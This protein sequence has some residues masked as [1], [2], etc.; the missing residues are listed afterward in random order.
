[1]SLVGLLSGCWMI[2]LVVYTRHYYKSRGFLANPDWNCDNW[3][4][5]LFRILFSGSAIAL[6]LS[7]LTILS[8]KLAGIKIIMDIPHVIPE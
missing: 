8:L 1:M 6:I 3:F 2:G 7:I 4:V 5:R